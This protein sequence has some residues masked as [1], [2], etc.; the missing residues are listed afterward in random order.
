MGLCLSFQFEYRYCIQEEEEEKEEEEEEEYSLVS[1]LADHQ[2]QRLAKNR[3]E[4]GSCVEGTHP[5][6]DILE[7]A[8]I[9]PTNQKSCA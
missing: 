9:L 2:H 1:H 7:L 6:R 8:W 4:G 5:E 3:Q